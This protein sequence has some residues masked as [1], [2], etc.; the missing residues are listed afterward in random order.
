MEI[1]K[2]IKEKS[3]YAINVCGW[4]VDDEDDDHVHDVHAF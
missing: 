4:W 3:G 2:R 1:Y